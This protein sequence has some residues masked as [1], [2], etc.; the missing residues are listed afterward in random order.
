MTSRSSAKVQRLS[1]QNFSCAAR[2]VEMR[3]A[4]PQE[5][6]EGRMVADNQNYADAV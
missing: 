4:L 5:G 2:C 1:L 6:V 3:S